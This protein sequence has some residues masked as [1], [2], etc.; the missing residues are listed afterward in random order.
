LFG[1]FFENCGYGEIDELDW[2]NE[3]KIMEIMN[4]LN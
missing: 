1:L 4:E 2:K 3:M